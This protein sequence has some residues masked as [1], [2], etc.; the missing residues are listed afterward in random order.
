MENVTKQRPFTVVP[1]FS[2]LPKSPLGNDDSC[3]LFS[4]N[5]F[6]CAVERFPVGRARVNSFLNTETVQFGRSWAENALNWLRFNWLGC[7]QEG[8]R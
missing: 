6:N 3:C 5:Y 8:L 7:A 4:N 2:Y 1:C